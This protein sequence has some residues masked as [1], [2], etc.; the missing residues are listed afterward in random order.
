MLGKV[1]YIAYLVLYPQMLSNQGVM[2]YHL[3]T[4][5]NSMSVSFLTSTE[6]RQL[7]SV[8]QVVRGSSGGQI[9]KAEA[10]QRRELCLADFDTSSLLWKEATRKSYFSDRE[11]D[12]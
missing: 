4:S 1:A 7:V 9:I 11:L 12:I 3:R 5:C 10:V 2:L 8:L 6:W